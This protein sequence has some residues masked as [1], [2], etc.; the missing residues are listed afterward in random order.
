MSP[1]LW[2][3]TTLAGREFPRLMGQED[4][5]IVIIGAGVAGLSLALHLADRGL[6]PV[7]LEAGRAAAGAAGRSAGVVA[8]QLVRHTPESV[9]KTLGASRGE[10]LLR[11]I[12]DG[13]NCVFQLIGDRLTECGAERGGFLAPARGMAGAARVAGIAAGWAPLRKDL[14][15]LSGEEVTQTAGVTGYQAAIFDPTGGSLNPLAFC[16]LLADQAVT[17]GASLFLDSRVLAVTRQGDHWRLRCRDG[18]IRA[19]LVIACANVGNGDL[20]PSLSRS[21]L[22]MP[23]TQVATEPLSAA[24]R[25]QILP[26]GQA[27]TDMEADVFSIRRDP[28]GHLITAYPMGR[29]GHLARGLP[30]LVNDR[31][32]AALPGYQRKKLAFAWTGIAAINPSLLPRFFA[33]DESFFALQACNGR[34]LALNSI[35]GRELAA[36]IAEDRQGDWALPVEKPAPVAG[37]LLAQYLPLLL[38]QT[39]RLKQRFF[40][41]AA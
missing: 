22:T 38:M 16:R 36:W 18:E 14:V 28:L 17:A 33:V 11:L 8:P 41:H 35:L 2:D 4:A 29:Q 19:A 7:I 31:L 3:E 21:V 15:V 27:M 26:G 23:V 1:T 34:G 6:R 30:D 5:E 12:G 13:A 40:P 20:H 9:I 32:A 10:T 25:R 37:Y 39:A 24:E